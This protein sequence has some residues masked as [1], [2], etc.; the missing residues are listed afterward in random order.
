M[1]FDLQLFNFVYKLSNFSSIVNV[2]GIFFAKY[3]AY[4]LVF[5]LIVFILR[6]KNIKQKFTFFL[7]FLFGG[8]VSR[9]IFVP[10]LRYFIHRPRP[11]EFLK[12]SPL[13][14]ESGWSFPSG[15]ISFFFALSFILLAFNK[16]WGIYFMVFSLLMGVARIF[17]GVHWPTDILGGIIVGYLT[18]LIFKY[19]FLNRDLNSKTI[20]ISSNSKSNVG[21]V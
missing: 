3:L 14:S 9:F 21:E 7:Y 6:Q 13:I 8:I 20:Q 10:F 1:A 18:F 5:I 11:F 15:H 17:V 12:F 19:L 16:K 4:I 2:V